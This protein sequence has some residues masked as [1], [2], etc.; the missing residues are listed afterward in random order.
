MTIWRT[1]LLCR[2]SVLHFLSFRILI[3]QA[4]NPSDYLCTTFKKCRKYKE[5]YSFLIVKF[6]HDKKFILNK[7]KEDSLWLILHQIL[8][9]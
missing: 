4:S 5:S 7:K 2:S 9:K 8:I 1:Q 3:H 6:N